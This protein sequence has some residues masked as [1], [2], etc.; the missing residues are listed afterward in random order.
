MSVNKDVWSDNLLEN[1]HHYLPFRQLRPPVQNIEVA[2]IA[3][4]AVAFL[5]G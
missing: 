2:L 5:G 3:E 4:G 1:L